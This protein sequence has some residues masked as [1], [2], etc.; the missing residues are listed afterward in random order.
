MLLLATAFVAP[1]VF[2]VGYLYYKDRY[3]PEPL[4]ALGVAYLLGIIAG[5]LC[6]RSHKARSSARYSPRMIRFRTAPHSTFGS[7]GM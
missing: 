2:W 5:W 1:T 4:R 6:L 7:A 3:R